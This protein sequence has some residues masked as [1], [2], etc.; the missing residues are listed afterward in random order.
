MLIFF[1]SFAYICVHIYKRRIIWSILLSVPFFSNISW[2]FF[3]LIRNSSTIFFFFCIGFQCKDVAQLKSSLIYGYLVV[4]N[5]PL[6][7]FQHLGLFNQTVSMKMPKLKDRLDCNTF[8][9]YCKWFSRKF[10][11]I[12][13][14]ACLPA[15]LPALGL[16]IFCGVVFADLMGEIYF[17]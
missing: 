6:D 15:A 13:K 16:V 12:Y 1:Q 7:I 17:H 3:Y 9:I 4:L 10:V 5:V 2:I 11:S 8:S 14:S